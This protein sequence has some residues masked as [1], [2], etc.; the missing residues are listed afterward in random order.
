MS[1]SNDESIKLWTYGGDLL[2]TLTGHSSF[3]FSVTLGLLG[4]FFSGSEDKTVIVW[5]NDA[6]DQLINHPNTVWMVRCDEDGDVITACNDG[7]ARV[8]SESEERKATQ[9]EIDSLER[10]SEMAS[11][12]GPSGMSEAQLQKLPNVSELNKYKGKND[13]EYR[14]FKNG[15]TPEV[16]VWKAASQEWEKIGEALGQKTSSFYEG[17]RYFPQG[18]YDYVFEV[19]D[20]SGIPKKLPYNDG[21]NPLEVAEKFLARE[22]LPKGYIE[23]ITTFI[24]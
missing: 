9:E 24:R 5:K 12:Q 14:I 23:Q 10:E 19:D 22:Q 11:S 8:F 3:V 6:K 17:D 15:N 18:E 1:C 20:E 21:D 4:R 13:G 7:L 2:N 16:Y